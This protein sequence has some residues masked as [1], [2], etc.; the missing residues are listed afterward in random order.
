MKDDLVAAL[1]EVI[2]HKKGEITLEQKILYR[3]DIHALRERY[4]LSQNE[5]ARLF[6]VS[7]RTLQQWEQGNRHPSGP[8][9]VLLKVI[10]YNPTIV[11]EAIEK[12]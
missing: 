9:Q 5:F 12:I 11:K 7:L 1:K 10:A 6:G 8:A 2:A 4:H 3:N